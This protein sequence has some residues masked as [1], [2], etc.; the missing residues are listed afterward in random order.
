M[1]SLFRSGPNYFS[2]L[3]QIIGGSQSSLYRCIKE[4][5]KN[6][7][8]FKPKF[9]ENRRLVKM[10]YINE[11]LKNNQQYW[12]IFIKSILSLVSR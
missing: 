8:I 2:R 1:L 12:G 3:H 10:M 4:L 6:E 7:I 11:E 9:T 5:E